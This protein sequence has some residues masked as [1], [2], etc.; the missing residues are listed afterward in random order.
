[1]AAKQ[2]TPPPNWP[3]PPSPGWSPP[4]G[5]Q[6]PSEWGPAP[7]GWNFYPDGGNWFSQHKLL[8]GV[9]GV[10]LLFIVIGVAGGGAND[11]VDT[12]DS[13][14]STGPSEAPAESPPAASPPAAAPPP[15][16][17]SPVAPAFSGQTKDDTV[18][19]PGDEIRLSGWT[20]TSAALKK[21]SSVFGKQLC[22]AVSMTNRDEKSQQYASFSWK[23]QSPSGDVK[24]TALSE[25]NNE[26][27]VGELAPGGMKTGTLCF[28]DPGAAG[29]Y[30]VLWEPDVF[31]STDRG[32]WIN[33]I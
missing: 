16:A 28:D 21:T 24:D 14:A 29:V 5:W 4:P 10:L 15:A 9:L 19:Q 25:S 1:M 18:A 32:V 13:T 12:A 30:I 23:L 7:N 26:F 17:P 3:A 11:T 33:K 31:S 27:G 8:S 20:T 6:P 22:T 2:W